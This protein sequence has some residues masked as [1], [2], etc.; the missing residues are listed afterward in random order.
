MSISGIMIEESRNQAFWYLYCYIICI[1]LYF[2]QYEEP[3]IYFLVSLLILLFCPPTRN[4]MFGSKK[5]ETTASTS[6]ALSS[7]PNSL[8]ALVKGTKMEGDVK[9][10]N[11]FRVDGEI[12]GNLDCNGKVIIG[13]TGSVQGQIRCENAM[14]EGTFKGKLYVKDLLNVRETAELDGEIE[15]GKLTVQSGAT[16]NVICK[17]G[18][19][20]ALNN[21]RALPNEA[22][23]AA[24]HAVPA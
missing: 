8:N 1:L 16:F 13:T 9:A 24:Q 5:K 12:I 18:G 21:G 4:A 23:K 10:D 15:T 19:G 6:T 22:A 7:S 14:I 2:L 3:S 17:M 11:D 20:T